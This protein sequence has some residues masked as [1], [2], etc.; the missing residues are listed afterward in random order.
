MSPEAELRQAEAWLAWDRNPCGKPPLKLPALRRFE[1]R[2]VHL[3]HILGVDVAAQPHGRMRTAVLHALEANYHYHREWPGKVAGYFEGPV[4]GT[5]VI[6]IYGEGDPLP[7][8][9]EPPKP[10]FMK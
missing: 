1:T 5:W 10:R 4:D 2:Q 8:Q 6:E 9:P 3:P 7:V